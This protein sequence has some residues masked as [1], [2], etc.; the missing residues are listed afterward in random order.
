VLPDG[1][2][3]LDSLGLL[4]LLYWI[5]TEALEDQYRRSGVKRSLP[6]EV[7]GIS[8][9]SEALAYYQQLCG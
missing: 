4:E 9:V 3:D 5:E 2:F 6:D 8:N 7:P 1:T